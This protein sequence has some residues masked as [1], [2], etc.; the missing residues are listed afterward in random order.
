M[1]F[2]GTVPF[3]FPEFWLDVVKRVC[4]RCRELARKPEKKWAI[5]DQEQIAKILQQ[6]ESHVRKLDMDEWNF[7][8]DW[9][10]WPELL[11]KHQDIVRVIHFKARRCGIREHQVES[12]RKHFPE[13]I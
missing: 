10:Q 8:H 3:A 1:F 2:D 13:V 12:V 6:H 4:D 5:G 9:D 7:C 11:A